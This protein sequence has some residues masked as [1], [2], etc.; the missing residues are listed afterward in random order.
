MTGNMQFVKAEERM[1][2]NF[3][4]RVAHIITNGLQIKFGGVQIGRYPDG[5]LRILQQAYIENVSNIKADLHNDIA[6]VLTAHG[7]MS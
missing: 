2:S 5:T 6:S 4:M 7:K 3:D 1:H